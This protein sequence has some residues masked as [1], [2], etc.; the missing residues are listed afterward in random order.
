LAALAKCPCYPLHVVRTRYRHYHIIFREPLV[1]SPR[2][3]G[4]PIRELDYARAWAGSLMSFLEEHG[5]QWLVFEE[6]FTE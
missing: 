3:P 5:L 4:A 1:V 2:K 6:A